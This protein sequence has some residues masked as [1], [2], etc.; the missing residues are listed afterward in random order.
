MLREVWYNDV[1]SMYSLW[2][3]LGLW[4]VWL[5]YHGCAT[6]SFLCTVNNKHSVTKLQGGGVLCTY[7]PLG[8][9]IVSFC[10]CYNFYIENITRYKLEHSV[11]AMTRTVFMQL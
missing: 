7:N 4:F 3:D 1:I 11:H 5:K 10:K 6:L 8:L 9:I 2:R